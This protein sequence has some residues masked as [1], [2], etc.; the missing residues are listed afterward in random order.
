MFSR[1]KLTPGRLAQHDE[2]IGDRLVASLSSGATPPRNLDTPT[3]DDGWPNFRLWVD[4]EIHEL[5]ARNLDT[6]SARLAAS[7]VRRRE[8]WQTP[9]KWAL[10]VSL[11]SLAVSAAAFL[12]TL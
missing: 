3:S 7:E 9:A 10:V 8:A 12:R 11:F 1:P 6:A 5:I 2:L 4:E